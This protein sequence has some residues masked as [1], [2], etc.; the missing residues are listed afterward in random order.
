M[1]PAQKLTRIIR[2]LISL[3]EEE[4]SRNPTFAERLEA[5]TA[6]LP[7]SFAKKPPRVKSATPSEP[8]PDVFKAYQDKGLEEFRFWLRSLDLRTLKAIVKVN[9]FDA[10]KASQR[11]T[12]PDK[13]VELVADQ[14]AARL[15]RGSG[16]LPSKVLG[17]ARE[18]L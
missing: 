8:P 17:D 1:Q 12:E 7:V 3:V 16:F 4:A 18:K 10:G 13:F 6:A 2:D 9:G 15:R 11:W 14:T 5:I